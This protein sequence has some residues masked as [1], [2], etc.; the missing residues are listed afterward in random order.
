MLTTLGI[1]FGFDNIIVKVWIGQST[2][3]VKF[4]KKD[5][6]K[7]YISTNRAV[8]VGPDCCAPVCL[9]VTSRPAQLSSI[10]GHCRAETVHPRHKSHR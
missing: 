5:V 4:E 8:T 10:N 6:L 7:P 1:D 9:A 3:L 2:D